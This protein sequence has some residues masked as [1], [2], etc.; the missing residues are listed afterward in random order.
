MRP[1]S[2]ADHRMDVRDAIC[3]KVRI[4]VRTSTRSW[5]GDNTNASNRRAAPSGFRVFTTSP[6]ASCAQ[7]QFDRQCLCLPAL[8]HVVTGKN[9]RR[10]GITPLGAPRPGSRGCA[11]APS[12][13]GRRLRSSGPAVVSPCR[14]SGGRDGTRHRRPCR[15]SRAGTR[16][17]GLEHLFQWLV[18]NPR[19]PERYLQRG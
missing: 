7:Q 9:L 10:P 2:P 16:C 11:A 14:A 1:T 4:N 15:D 6:G 5:R 17:A 13:P 8:R 19:D 12:R 18:E 3:I